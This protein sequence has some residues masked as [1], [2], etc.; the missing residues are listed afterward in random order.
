VGFDGFTLDPPRRQLTRDSKVLHLTPKA[1]D[2]LV[3]LVEQA[4]RVVP[5]RELH[6]RLWTDTFVSD[7]TLVGVVKE[8]RRVLDDRSG[9][10][11][12][13]RTVHRV[14]YAFSRTIDVSVP[15]QPLLHWLLLDERR[16]ELRQGENVIGR[17][18]TAVVWLDSAS[19][20]RRHARIVIDEHGVTLEDLGSKNGTMVGGLRVAGKRSLSDGDCISVGLARLLYR[21]AAADRTTETCIPS[22]R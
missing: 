18:P 4:P 8:L 10:R 16:I 22:A 2:L 19:V 3:L 6:E 12:L 1:F 5:K 14:G 9:D 13:I 11:P 20:S 17:D 21:T 7:A 15:L